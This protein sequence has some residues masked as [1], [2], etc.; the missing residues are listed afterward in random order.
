MLV[1]KIDFL[2]TVTTDTISRLEDEGFNLFSM[3]FGE[4]SGLIESDHQFT[5]WHS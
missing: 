1:K 2:G 3:L 5:V 4:A